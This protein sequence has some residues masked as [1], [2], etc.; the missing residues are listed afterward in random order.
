MGD[1]AASGGYY[2]SVPASFIVAQPTTITGSIGIFGMIPNVSG[3]TDKLGVTFDVVKTNRFADMPT[4]TRP[5]SLEE[6]AIMQAYVERGYKTF[7]SRCA[8]SRH[9]KLF[10]DESAYCSGTVWS[11]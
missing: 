1:Y 11:G 6:K 3:L 2:I 9:T 7:L 4:I 8:Y 5:M 10:P